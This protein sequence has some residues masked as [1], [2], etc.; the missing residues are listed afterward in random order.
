MS[1]VLFQRTFRIAKKCVLNFA[2][3]ESEDEGTK[4]GGK[5]SLKRKFEEVAQYEPPSKVPCFK[6]KKR[7]LGM[8]LELSI[9]E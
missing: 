8:S 2:E 6:C 7:A 1:C 5:K 4:P 3:S 9:D